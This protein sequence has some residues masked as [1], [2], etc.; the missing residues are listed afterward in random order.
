MQMFLGSQGGL[1]HLKKAGLNRM[2]KIG[3]FQTNFEKTHENT[4]YP[5]NALLKKTFFVK[6]A[7]LFCHLF[8]A[9]L[10]TYFCYSWSALVFTLDRAINI[11]FHS[12]PPASAESSNTT[13]F[14]CQKCAI[15]LFINTIF[16]I[17]ATVYPQ[18]LHFIE[19]F[20]CPLGWLCLNN[21]KTK[22]YTLNLNYI[23]R[24]YVL[25]R[26]KIF[27]VRFDP[28]Q[29]KRWALQVLHVAMRPATKS[30][31]GTDWNLQYSKLTQD[32]IAH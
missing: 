12:Y 22:R 26:K 3:F 2:D 17:Y 5:Q 27:W 19:K 14:F 8:F 16:F 30:E 21:V 20:F 11:F 13:I 10:L 4:K 31:T 15:P 18:G 23:L 7:K 9:S 29:V 1:I 6:S 24:Y 25:K 28:A 32:P